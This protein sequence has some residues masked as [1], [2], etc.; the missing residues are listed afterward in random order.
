MT[1][2]AL[3]VV[4]DGIPA[5]VIERVATPH[6]DSIAAVGAYGRASVGGPPGTAAET[7]T[8]S[9][10]GYMS[11]VTGTWADKH[12][13]RSNYDLEPNYAVWN[14]FRL[15]KAANP[16]LAIGIF[17]TWT[18]NRTVLLNAGD[19]PSADLAFDF[20]ADGF[21]FDE[22]RFPPTEDSAHILAIDREV[23]ARAAKTIADHGPDLSWV[24]WQFTDDVAHLHGDSPEFDRA[25]K[26][27]D[28]LVGVVWRAIRE[29]QQRSGEDWLVL[30]TTDHGRDAD[31][32]REHGGQSQRQRT[33]WIATNSQRLTPR[34]L[35]QPSIVDIYPSIAAH[36]GLS[37]P[38]QVARQLDGEAFI[39]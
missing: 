21:E 2:K 30:V 35:Q 15:A 20:I 27:M 6:I 31:T 34:F 4:I 29:R 23:A 25:V 24:Y 8:S 22:G 28:E 3:F 14:L 11:L 9:A 17:S 38:P 18:D 13:V 33:T 1:P 16:Q 37:V 19:Q 7:P 5:D 12:R 39:Q 26:D 36:L 10:P 32:G